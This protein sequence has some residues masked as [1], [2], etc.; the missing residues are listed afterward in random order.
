ME[1]YFTAISQIELE[2]KPGDKTSRHIAT[3]IKI[4]PS[5][6]LDR[7]KYVLNNEPTLEGSR[8][9]TEALT[10][11]LIANIHASHQLGYVD[12]AQH[13][14]HIIEQL[15]SG[16]VRIANISKGNLSE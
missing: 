1:F 3:N 6:N 15:E 12:S 2:H 13:L 10:Q 11:G 8:V 14:R 16:F 5:D 4:V 9:L 7:E